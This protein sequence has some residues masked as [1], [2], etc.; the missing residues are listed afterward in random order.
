MIRLTEKDGTLHIQM[1]ED[2]DGVVRYMKGNV[3]YDSHFHDIWW[4]HDTKQLNIGV[5]ELDV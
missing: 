2:I 5:K 4:D 1:S 3:I